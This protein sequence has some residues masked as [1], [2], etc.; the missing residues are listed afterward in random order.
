METL[1]FLKSYFEDVKVITMQG[2]EEK[3]V[4]KPLLNFS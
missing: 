3:T 4:F 1:D 2:V